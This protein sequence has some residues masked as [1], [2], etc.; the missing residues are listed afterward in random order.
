[1]SRKVLDVGNCGPDHT[2]IRDMLSREFDADVV[3]AHSLQDTLEQLRTAT[4]DLV[5]I[6]RKLDQDYSDGVE[7]VRAIKQQPQIA[8]IPVML[9]TNYKEH[10]DTAVEAGAV[11]GFGKL[12][13]QSAETRDR[14]Q[15]Y[16]S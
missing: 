7:I 8:H 3:Q 10:Q 1:M 11:P 13:L 14:L 4:F 9:I 6:N 2:A 5:L 12:E 15:A 16:L